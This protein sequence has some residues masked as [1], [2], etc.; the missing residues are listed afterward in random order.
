MFTVNFTYLCTTIKINILICVI[1]KCLYKHLIKKYFWVYLQPKK[2]HF[3]HHKKQVVN[4]RLISGIVESILQMEMIPIV[5]LTSFNKLATIIQKKMT[6]M[7]RLSIKRIKSMLQS[8]SQVILHSQQLH[9]T[10]KTTCHG[11][12][13]H[14]N[15]AHC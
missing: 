9:C 4:Y 6:L 5:S 11:N 10:L 7:Q 12:P 15:Q 2:R 1:T 13:W 3:I 8:F 14:F